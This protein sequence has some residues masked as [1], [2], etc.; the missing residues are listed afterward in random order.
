M[1]TNQRQMLTVGLS[2]IAALTIAAATYLIIYVAPGEL[3]AS[4]RIAVTVLAIG[5][6]FL[7]STL[8]AA[9]MARNEKRSEFLRACG[10]LLSR[11][12]LTREDDDADLSAAGQPAG[13]EPPAVH[14]DSATITFIIGLMKFVERDRGIQLATLEQLTLQI[15]KLAADAQSRTMRESAY[16]N[17]PLSIDAKKVQ[18]IVDEAKAL[19]RGGD[20]RAAVAKLAEAVSIANRPDT[21][22][23]AEDIL[24]I[25][26][27]RA[28]WL[29]RSGQKD[30]AVKELKM[31]VGEQ[32]ELLGAD[33]P[34]TRWTQ[35]QLEI[36]Q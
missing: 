4:G 26:A 15:R 17:Q 3:D 19:G 11:L 34:D 31:L 5:S 8:A 1:K 28:Y 24:R 10:E 32:T 27:H 12:A 18:H 13:R 7:A 9:R 21:G 16:V 23:E 14:A 6:F 35:E 36:I 20:S 2:A 29:A 25:R 22:L 33:H 30:D